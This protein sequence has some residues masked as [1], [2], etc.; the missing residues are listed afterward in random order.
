MAV[1][2]IECYN[3]IYYSL[4]INDILHGEAYNVNLIEY[5][6][7]YLITAKPKSHK[8]HEMIGDINNKF[9]LSWYCT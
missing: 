7:V 4:M 9:L 2:I 6:G 8:M 5:P 3:M 1:Q